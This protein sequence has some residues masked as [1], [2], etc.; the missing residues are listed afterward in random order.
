MP[1]YEPKPNPAR[2][3]LLSRPRNEE[4]LANRYKSAAVSLLLA[5]LAA[6]LYSPRFGGPSAVAAAALLCSAAAVRWHPAARSSA[7]ALAVSVVWLLWAGYWHA[8][9]PKVIGAG[10]RLDAVWALVN[11]VPAVLAGMSSVACVATLRRVLPPSPS[12]SH[13]A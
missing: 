5:G 6:A 12:G 10:P 11:V 2:R 3:S 7:G 13:A 8:T 1:S 4:E 9:H